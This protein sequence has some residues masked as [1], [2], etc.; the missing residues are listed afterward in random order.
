MLDET[1]T[2]DYMINAGSPIVHQALGGRKLTSRLTKYDSAHT[3]NN[4]SV[5]NS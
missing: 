1:P 2:M 4:N 3:P 5:L